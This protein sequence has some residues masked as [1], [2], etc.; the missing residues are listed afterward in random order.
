[1]VNPTIAIIV[2]T[3]RTLRH[4]RGGIGFGFGLSAAAR[5]LAAGKPDDCAQ[6]TTS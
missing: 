5:W 1:V 4:G 2:F 3:I 6:K